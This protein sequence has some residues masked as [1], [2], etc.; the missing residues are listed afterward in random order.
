MITKILLIGSF[1]HTIDEILKKLTGT[2]SCN[3]VADLN[4]RFGEEFSAIIRSVEYEREIIR[5]ESFLIVV[6]IH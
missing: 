6:T 5:A 1:I 4:S 2:V 3:L